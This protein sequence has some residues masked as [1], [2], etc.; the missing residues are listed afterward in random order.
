MANLVVD[1][2]L[3]NVLLLVGSNLVLAL[4]HGEGLMEFMEV[5]WRDVAMRHNGIEGIIDR[6]LARS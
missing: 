3:G 5:S 6:V 2:F 1:L 4:Y